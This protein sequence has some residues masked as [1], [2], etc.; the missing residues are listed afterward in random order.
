MTSF[1]NRIQTKQAFRELLV[2]P[3]L[4]SNLNVHVDKSVGLFHV[5]VKYRLFL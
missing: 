4:V 2:A 5:N 3:A 1:I